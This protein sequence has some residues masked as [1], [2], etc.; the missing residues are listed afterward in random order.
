MV[1]SNGWLWII[2]ALVFAA[3]ELALPGWFFLGLAAAVLLMGLALLS[4]LW[5]GGLPLALVVTAILTGV[6]WLVLRRIFGTS[7]SEVRIWTR[8]I[9]DN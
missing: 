4:G 5:G 8:D 2:V 1:W 3:L 9:N 6:I 7:R